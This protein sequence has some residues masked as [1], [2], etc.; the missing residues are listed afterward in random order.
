MSMNVSINVL[1]VAHLRY[2]MRQLLGKKNSRQF[3][4]VPLTGLQDTHF[5]YVTGLS[6][7]LKHWQ[8][9]LCK[10]TVPLHSF[11]VT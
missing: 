10:G 9:T 6:T 11:C 1:F 5:A 2:N 8:E 3:L 4:H 7:P